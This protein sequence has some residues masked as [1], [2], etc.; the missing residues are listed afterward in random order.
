MQA[1]GQG[2]SIGRRGLAAGAAALVLAGPAQA[3]LPLPPGNALAFR[4]LRDGSEVGTHR[5]SFS[6]RGD[7]TVAQVATD[8][9]VAYFSIT[10]FRLAH[11]AAEI[12]DDNGFR[13]IESA[14]DNNGTAEW[15][16]AER[17]A[18]G[19]LLVTGSGTAPYAAPRGA[20]ASTYWNPAILGAPVISSQDG[21]LTRDNVSDGPVERVPV[22]DGTVLARR[23]EMGGD[24][25]LAIWYD[26]QGQWAHLRFRRD[27]SV[28]TYLRG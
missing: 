14:T 8:I 16:R 19:T 13:G 11:R 9:A 7:A 5:V 22:A 6:Q 3:A 26:L 12:W 23:Y 25:G 24:L 27:G 20:L 15:M 1:G 10:M 2:R 17:D 21:H 18:D 4:I 28:I